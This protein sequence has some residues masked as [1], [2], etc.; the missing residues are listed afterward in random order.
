[1]ARKKR[2]RYAEAQRR[3]IL[4]TA[5]RERL[6]AADVKKKYGVTPVTYYSWRKKYGVGTRQGGGPR[7]A[8]AG[9]ALN[10][11]GITQQVRSAV[12]S[13][14]RA[15]VQDVVRAEVDNYLASLFGGGAGKRRV[16]RRRRRARATA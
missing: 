3:Q 5:V 9:V 7:A 4:E 15:L 11:G 16:R 2:T 12:Q 10:G 8:A 6:T 1:M 14:V 13:K